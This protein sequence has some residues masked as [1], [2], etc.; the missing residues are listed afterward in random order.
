MIWKSDKL[1]T[2]LAPDLLQNGQVLMIFIDFPWFYAY[3]DSLLL[4]DYWELAYKLDMCEYQL[5]ELFL[6][7]ITEKSYGWRHAS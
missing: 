7:V 4:R 1:E 2:F 5:L 6:M 3:F